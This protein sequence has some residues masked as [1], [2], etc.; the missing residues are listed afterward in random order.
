[1]SPSTSDGAQTTAEVAD[2]QGRTRIF[3]RPI[4]APSVLGLFGFAAATRL[5]KVSRPSRMPT[6]WPGSIP[7]ALEGVFSAARWGTA[8]AAEGGVPAGPGGSR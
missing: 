3:L 4:A 6:R 8:R 5:V 7:A 2:W 1:M